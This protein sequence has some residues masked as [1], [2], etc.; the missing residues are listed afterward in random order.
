MKQSVSSLNSSDNIV[1][2]N[3]SHPNKKIA[4]NEKRERFYVLN[5][6]ISKRLRDTRINLGLAPVDVC[7]RITCLNKSHFSEWENG[8]K[9]IPLYWLCR[10]AD[11]YG[12]SLDYLVGNVDEDEETRITFTIKRTIIESS[13]QYLNHLAE[14]MQ[15]MTRNNLILI[16]AQNNSLEIAK[17]L[18]DAVSRLIELNPETWLELR[19]GAKVELLLEQLFNSLKSTDAISRQ[20]TMADKTEKGRAHLVQG[21]LD[22]FGLS[23]NDGTQ[24]SKTS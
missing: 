22:L 2:K 12:V 7:E 18:K 3:T 13:Q 19:N 15:T 23:G 9:P 10:L 6:K 24:S 4:A 8:K 20:L 11:L 5:K 17:Q 16:D 14:Q 1:L 21:N